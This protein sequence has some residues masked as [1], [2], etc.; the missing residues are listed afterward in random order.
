MINNRIKGGLHQIPPFC[1]KVHRTAN[2]D[3][4]A[5]ELEWFLVLTSGGS[6]VVTAH[7]V[8]NATSCQR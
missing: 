3:Q 4:F 8:I 7:K 6:G 5:T 1:E 2:R